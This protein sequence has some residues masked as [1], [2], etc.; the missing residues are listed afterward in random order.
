MP[1]LFSKVF[2]SKDYA[3]QSKKDAA[4]AHD[5]ATRPSL[6]PRGDAWAKTEVSPEEVQELLRGCTQEIKMRGTLEKME[7]NLIKQL[8]D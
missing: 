6:Q 2:R 1:S 5:A 8:T 7:S 4:A 3:A